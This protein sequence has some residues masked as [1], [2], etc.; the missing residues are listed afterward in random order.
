MNA[1]HSN[2]RTD[3]GGTPARFKLLT[4]DEVLA[5]PPPEWLV[6]GFIPAGSLAQLYGRSGAGK[7]FVAIDLALSIAAG[8][9]WLDE[10]VTKKGPVVYVAA[11][12]LAGVQARVG[13]WL[14]HHQLTPADLDGF[15]LLGEPLP[16]GEA[17]E[18]SALI[19]EAKGQF[20]DLPLSMVVLD[21]QAR[22]TEGLDENHARD[23]GRAVAEADRMKRETGATVLLVH[24]SGYARGH[25]RGSTA[26]RAALDTLIHL[27]GRKG[28]VRLACEKQKDAPE[29]REIHFRLLEVAESLVVVGS[30][31]DSVENLLLARQGLSKNQRAAL[32]A[33]EAVS[34][35][36]SSTAWRTASGLV[37]STFYGVRRQ[38]TELGLVSAE[39]DVYTITDLTPDQS[40]PVQSKS[41][42]GTS[43]T[44]QESNPLLGVGPLDQDTANGHGEQR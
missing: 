4:V 40:G 33:L 27:D 38:L 18:V 25:P 34:S 37:K 11:E 32:V 30:S 3:A 24:H 6:E 7:S 43:V 1:S 28:V 19:S 12:G 10:H 39:D 26:V 17:R 44:V 5:L 16:L 8:R 31:P 42:P 29:F 36:L 35:G 20:P 23:M 2:G 14:A 21:T 13:A 9:S 15:R 22:C 41:G